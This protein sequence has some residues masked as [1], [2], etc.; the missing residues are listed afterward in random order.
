[1]RRGTAR[2]ASHSYASIVLVLIAL[3]SA[4]GSQPTVS[5]DVRYQNSDAV[6]D[7]RTYRVE[8]QDMPEFLKPML[9]DEVSRVL[10]ERGFDY[11]EGAAHAV[12]LLA[13]ENRP[14]ASATTATGGDSTDTAT[15]TQQIAARFNARVTAELS[16]SVS[17]ER[18]WAGSLSRVH[19]VTEGAYM[20]EAPAR[21]AMREAFRVV[22]AD[23]PNR[24]EQI[25]VE[26]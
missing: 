26:D 15:G 13:F 10:A 22:F 18:L 25:W 12:L 21:A 24:L 7:I 16:D 2:P 3:L 19:Y 23:L 6:S 1:M 14:L 17:G 11:T 20:H 8:F 4:C 9:R 5:A